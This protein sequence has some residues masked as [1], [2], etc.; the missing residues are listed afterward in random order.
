MVQFY[1]HKEMKEDNFLP[2]HVAG[3]SSRPSARQ[4]RTLQALRRTPA[5]APGA[6][7]STGSGPAR[8]SLT[9]QLHKKFKPP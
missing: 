3:E 6:A 8:P 9:H 5:L 1:E 2:W 7:H 4:A